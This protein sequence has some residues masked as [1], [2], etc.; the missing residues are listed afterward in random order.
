M[1]DVRFE[2]LTLATMERGLLMVLSNSEP[3]TLEQIK[4]LR[5]K[6]DLPSIPKSIVGMTKGPHEQDRQRHTARSA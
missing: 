5:A 6:L 4:A 3:M 2:R 1:D